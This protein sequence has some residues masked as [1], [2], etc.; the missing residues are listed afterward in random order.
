MKALIFDMDGTLTEPRRGISRNMIDALRSVSNSYKLYLV[1]GSDM[2]K[3][4]EQ[5]PAK[6]LLNVF[7]KVFPCNGTRVYNTNLDEDDE[8]GALEPELVFKETLLDHYSQ[9]DMNHLISRLLEIAANTHTK[10]KTGT[11]VEWREGQINFSL[12]GRNC[13][14][15]QREDYIIWDKKSGERMRIVEL[16]QGEFKSW[17]LEFSIGGQISIDITRKGWDKTCALRYIQEDPTDC[18]F[19]GDKI[20]PGGNDFEIAKACGAYYDIKSPSDLLSILT[21]YKPT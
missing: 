11:F 15:E 12:I 8:S 10:H 7:E 20:F 21:K 18:V 3:V 16:L 17:G 6:V 4:E 13:S 2:I 5:I 19:F 9:S 14:S 1:T